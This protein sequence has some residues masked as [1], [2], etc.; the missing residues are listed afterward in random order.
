MLAPITSGWL[1]DHETRE[2]IPDRLSDRLAAERLQIDTRALLARL[3]AALAAADCLADAEPMPPTGASCLGD[4][5]HHLEDAVAHARAVL[6]RSIDD[7]GPV[8]ER[9]A[10]AVQAAE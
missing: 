6:T 10:R 7:I 2:P 3:E 4:V 1:D 9:A 5:A 8:H